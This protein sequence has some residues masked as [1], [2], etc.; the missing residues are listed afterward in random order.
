MQRPADFLG[1][2]R[3]GTVGHSG[4]TPEVKFKRATFLNRPAQIEFPGG[5]QAPIIWD[6]RS[7]EYFSP[8]QVY[9]QQV[10]FQM[11]F[12]GF[13]R[14]RFAAKVALSAG[15]YT[16]GDYFREKVAH[17]DTR[18]M[19]YAI[20]TKELKAIKSPDPTLYYDTFTPVREEDRGLHSVISSLCTALRGS[21]V[22]INPG[23]A[24]IGVSVGVLGNFI[25]S[26]NMPADTTNFP[27]TPDFDLGHCLVICNGVLG[28]FSFR[29]LLL[30]YAVE[31]QSAVQRKEQ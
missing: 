13:S 19:M 11:K 5:G 10:A 3:V 17:A 25:G 2:A 12:S 31:L 7:R 21:I 6:A 27:T 30:N 22:M 1:E 4:K 29:E 18:R 23:P 24:N 14:L 28:R 16:L 26:I 9:G 15:F 8:E 20:N